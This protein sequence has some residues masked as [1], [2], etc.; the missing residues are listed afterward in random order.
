MKVSNF[1]SLYN[2][3]LSLLL[4][5]L[6]LLLLC[7]AADISDAALQPAVAL[8][9]SEH[10]QILSVTKWREID[11]GVRSSIGHGKRP[12]KVFALQT[13]IGISGNM[14]T[15][16]DSRGARDLFLIP[17][18]SLSSDTAS[19]GNINS[20]SLDDYEG[21]IL[22][23]FRGGWEGVF[24]AS[25]WRDSTMNSN[26]MSAVHFFKAIANDSSLT[27]PFDLERSSSKVS[28]ALSRRY[29]LSENCGDFTDEC[30]QGRYMTY[31]TSF[32]EIPLDRFTGRMIFHVG[33]EG[34]WNGPWTLRL[35]S[36]MLHDSS[37]YVDIVMVLVDKNGPL[38]WY[39]WLNSTFL[40]NVLL[41]VFCLVWV[42]CFIVGVKEL[43]MR[44]SV[45]VPLNERYVTVLYEDIDD[46]DHQCI[47]LYRIM[48]AT[49]EIF[50]KI[51]NQLFLL[52]CA[53]LNRLQCCCSWRWGQRRRRWMHDFTQP[54][55][56][57]VVVEN[58]NNET[59]SREVEMEN[60]ALN[61]SSS[62]TNKNNNND[63]THEEEGI[64][65]REERGE[66]ENDDDDDD[67]DDEILCRI[68]RCSKPV[69][70]LFA[71]CSCDGSSKYVHKSCLEKWRT[72]TSN[73]EHKRVCAECKTPYVLML[74]RIPVSPDEFLNSPICVPACRAFVSRA[75]MMLLFV[76][77]LW[78]GGYYLKFCMYLV[79]G[80]DDGVIWSSAHLY[81]WVLGLYYI[82]ALCLNMHALEYVLRDFSESWQQMLILLISVAVVEIPLS[83][84]G[85]I[86]LSWLLNRSWSF[87]V[88][89]G[90]GIMVTAVLYVEVLPHLYEHLQSLL[91]VRVV[92]A[93][94]TESVR[95]RE[96]L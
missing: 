94:R 79:T 40:G 52:Q 55:S 35:Q 42:L 28:S 73:E 74:E 82:I 96:I 24:A 93:P 20:C 9:D 43:G 64:Q 17:Y 83:Y 87:E 18:C 54:N 61:P 8:F 49:Q 25:L 2:P 6:L 37:T 15:V 66:R 26:V 47:S 71:P 89:Y 70:E 77:L 46:D 10:T 65:Q 11:F 80:L 22:L 81:H 57:D 45:L 84:V 1:I 48:L 62:G 5:L 39:L 68:C 30:F 56:E 88:S 23:R 90:L 92:V 76:L 67:D 16:A 69:E 33:V 44:L 50:L 85:Q 91:T 19:T 21:Y 3:R 78:I 60:V 4:L 59:G 53:F 31:T 95:N 29:E 41:V 27:F 7:Y 86:V 58:A 75:A 72:M 36:T 14:K 12:A 34:G 63:Q 32:K 38:K 13:T 51:L